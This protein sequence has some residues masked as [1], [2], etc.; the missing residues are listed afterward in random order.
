[1]NK[2]L[3]FFDSAFESRRD[4]GNG[5]KITAS[6][7]IGFLYIVVDVRVPD[8]FLHQDDATFFSYRIVFNTTQT[9]ETSHIRQMSA[10]QNDVGKVAQ[11]ALHRNQTA[12]GLE[13]LVVTG[14][15]ASSS[16]RS[17]MWAIHEQSALSV[18]M[19]SSSVV[20]LSMGFSAL[21]ARC[22]SG[23]GLKCYRTGH[24]GCW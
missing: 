3:Q 22:H 24:R 7:S 1:M 23:R 2:S 19:V 16:G 18:G 8:D 15:P 4:N 20:P 17:G 5:Y 10:H 9:F 21:R 13:K 11:G 14:G 6:Q 12:I